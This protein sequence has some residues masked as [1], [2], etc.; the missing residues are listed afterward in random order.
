MQFQQKPQQA[1]LQKFTR[2]YH[3]HRKVKNLQ[4]E[5]TIRL[6]KKKNAERRML[7][8]FKMHSSATVI[9]T[10]SMWYWHKDR[11]VNQ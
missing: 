2:L 1:F 6:K 7:F 10:T 9:K 4:E 8:D 5:E 3:L 11:H